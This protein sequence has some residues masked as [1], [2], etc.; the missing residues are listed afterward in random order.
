[1]I[2]AWLAALAIHAPGCSTADVSADIAHCGR[3]RCLLLGQAFLRCGDLRIWADRIEV[4]LGKGGAF[5]TG[6]ADG[7]VTVID[8]NQV[9]T[10]SR[11][12]LAEGGLLGTLAG[13]TL[14]I[15][16]E[17]APEEDALAWAAGAANQAILNGDQVRKQDRRYLL[18][19]ATYT[20]CDCRDGPP[21]WGLQSDRVE[22]IPGER[23]LLWGP[24]LT[25]G[26]VTATPPLLPTSLPLTERAPGLLIPKLKLR[27]GAPTV[28]VPV[29]WPLGPSWDVT[30]APG[31][32]TDWAA[33]RL[34]ARLRYAPSRSTE[35]WASAQWT[36]DY[37]G[38]GD[39]APAHRLSLRWE[40]HATAPG[41]DWDTD[42]SWH[43]DDAYPGE[44]ETSIH[45]R[46]LKTLPSRSRLHLSADGWT[47][48]LA[49]AYL[50]P[51]GDDGAGAANWEGK[52]AEAW[53]PGPWLHVAREPLALWQRPGM[54]LAA[55]AEA[56]AG[57]YGPWRA[58][59][60]AYAGA[61]RAGMFM[62][63]QRGAVSV[64]AGADIVASV[65][66]HVQ[67]APLVTAGVSVL[68]ARA[69]G[70]GTHTLEPR[71]RFASLPWR[72]GAA[73]PGR[74]STLSD[75]EAGTDLALSLHQG[76][77]ARVAV[78]LE[79]PLVLGEDPAPLR[80]GI[81]A[82]PLHAWR[83][84][85][86]AALLGP[87]STQ[88]SVAASSRVSVTPFT[89]DASYLRFSA[90]DERLVRRTYRLAAALPRDAGEV[91]WTHWGEAGVRYAAGNGSVGYRALVLLPLPPGARH[92]DPDR[93]YVLQHS[94]TASLR[95]ACRCWQLDLVAAIPGHSKK[96]A[97]RDAQV[98]VQ[99]SI[100]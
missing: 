21:T 2:G 100:Y 93:P 54:L 12:T 33:P 91:D 95:S 26:G 14:R 79:Q 8:D 64:D 43:G 90:Q 3:D 76:F 81:A 51:F 83:V 86:D 27:G 47:G 96:D 87:A 67:L 78:D 7:S 62:A 72:A 52:T 71:L 29:F 25:L 1:L 36:W 82:T 30:L 48:A 19:N 99:Y 32:R 94:L 59:A 28:D 56:E 65:W 80:L 70:W 58:G 73:D 49:V 40:H 41:I 35:G 38:H 11:V 53:H 68:M 55:S 13:A 77:G 37:D 42:V 15:K 63:G 16:T 20:H 10:C 66:N 60:R 22:A 98:S 5:D 61:L 39:P 92:S 57:H 24:R 85:L 34:G 9:M 75:L 46:V 74:L 97:V 31:V 18:D 45:R 44:F 4:A 17:A 6:E 23:A 89:F 84:R 50:Q 88:H 69:Y